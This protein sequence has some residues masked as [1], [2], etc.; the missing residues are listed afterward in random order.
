MNRLITM[1]SYTML[2]NTIMIA[3]ATKPMV[4]I[5]AVLFDQPGKKA[6]ATTSG[7]GLS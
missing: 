6:P 4:L 7:Q 3:I 5:T 2:A 1:N